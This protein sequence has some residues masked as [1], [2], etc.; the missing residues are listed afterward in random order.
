MCSNKTLFMKTSS[1]LGLALGPW[2]ADPCPR[3]CSGCP[4]DLYLLEPRSHADFSLEAVVLKSQS[5][6]GYFWSCLGLIRGSQISAA[7]WVRPLETGLSL[8]AKD[9]SHSKVFLDLTPQPPILMNGDQRWRQLTV[10]KWDPSWIH[11]GMNQFKTRTG[12]VTLEKITALLGVSLSS[13]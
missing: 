9:K 12:C 6:L 5:G 1:G 7:E 13:L 10:L 11:F 3:A 4:E 8:R 2:Y